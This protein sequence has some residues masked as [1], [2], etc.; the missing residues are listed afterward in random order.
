MPRLPVILFWLLVAS[1][2][3]YVVSSV[4][5]L[6]EQVATHFGGGG[7]PNG[8]MT[9]NVY[10]IFILAF[11]LGLPFFIIGLH[12][13]LARYAGSQFNIPN[14]EY[15]LAPE[16]RDETLGFMLRH[17]WWLG[18]LLLSFMIAVHHLLLIS[19]LTSPPRLSAV[20]FLL[21]LAM[22]LVGLCGWILVLVTR[23]RKKL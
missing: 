23:F 6:P 22:F 18:C 19:N 10:Q 9:R 17:S 13:L 15:W 12:Y 21:F 1:F 3:N 7:V 11:G 8:W 14:R 2:V 16:R 5:T 4:S 20:P